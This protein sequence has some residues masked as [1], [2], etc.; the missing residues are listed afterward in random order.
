[1][2]S[3]KITCL[4]ILLT[5]CGFFFSTFGLS[6][7]P[8]VPAP[9]PPMIYWEGQSTND[10]V[11]G[12]AIPG[13]NG[14]NDFHIAVDIS[15]M[16]SAPP[17]QWS[18]HG[19]SSM[20]SYLDWAWPPVAEQLPPIYIAK[21]A[22]SYH[23][24]FEPYLAVAGDT[25]RLT[26]TYA[27]GSS[28][29]GYVVVDGV[30]WGDEVAWGGQSGFDY[31]GMTGIE[32]N[33][34]DDWLIEVG[35]EGFDPR[36]VASWK[37]WLDY[38]G[39]DD[40]FNA[41]WV[42]PFDPSDRGGAMP[43]LPLSSGGKAQLYINPAFAREGDHFVIQATLESGDVIGWQLAGGGTD[44]G[45]TAV[46]YGRVDSDIIGEMALEPNG[47]N[48]IQMEVFDPAL[49]SGRVN[50][51]II[52]S[53][54]REWLAPFEYP[55]SEEI[56][57][58]IVQFEQRGGSVLI[59]LDNSDDR[60]GEFYFVTA[61]L[62]SKKMVGWAVAT[63]R[64]NN[65]PEAIWL[66]QAI[67]RIS[68][69]TPQTIDPLAPDGDL[70]LSVQVNHPLLAL[71]EVVTWEIHGGKWEWGGAD[72]ANQGVSPIVVAD[73]AN[74]NPA[75]NTQRT[76]CFADP[77]EPITR[78]EHFTINAI[79]SDGNVIHWRLASPGSPRLTNIKWQRPERN[80]YQIE[81]DNPGK[82]IGTMEVVDTHSGKR[83]M[84]VAQGRAAANLSMNARGERLSLK[85]RQDKTKLAPGAKLHVILTD[86]LGVRHYG[87][88]FVG[89]TY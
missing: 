44:W 17:I 62:T 58:R 20:K 60:A 67:D 29:T 88:C 5:G 65:S 39:H 27:D 40:Y 6:A 79:L 9:Q 47:V 10:F 83:W 80:S 77:A 61:V 84:N 78:G 36:D 38:G 48:D 15:T 54:N 14:I 89:P 21:D 59:T 8:E 81:L 71:S 35:D 55:T 69:I 72:P 87:E 4:R 66:G 76:I 75:L 82:I 64:S 85:L 42:H 49:S 11:G 22:Q 28:Q 56:D 34:C 1:M 25:L 7:Q 19:R 45:K 51:V 52:S 68:R 33:E 26:I 3:L 23:L 31:V 43:I 53:E 2:K 32:P 16:L 18:I 12:G 73:E 50:R 13:A 86:Q 24:F 74:P 70:D 37:I 30:H 57:R 63:T 46:Y 41:R